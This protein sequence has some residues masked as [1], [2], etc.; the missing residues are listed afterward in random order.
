MVSFLSFVTS[1]RG[2][3]GMLFSRRKRKE[4]ST[5]ISQ[6]KRQFVFYTMTGVF[7]FR[8]ISRRGLD[9]HL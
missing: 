8:F 3:V 9:Y 1:G 2:P 5:S 6:E 7:G 4:F